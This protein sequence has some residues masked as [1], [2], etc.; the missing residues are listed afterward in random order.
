M[1]NEIRTQLAQSVSNGSLNDSISL[2]FQTDQATALLADGVQI[3]GTSHE[4][5][6]LGDVTNMGPSTIVNGDATNYVTLGI[7][8]TGAFVPV[9]DIAPGEGLS[10]VKAA[11]GVTLYVKANTAPVNIRR[12]IPSL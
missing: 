3:V 6:N 12:F 8:D 2:A 7:D 9:L 4:A 1:A 5:L 10:G 11:S